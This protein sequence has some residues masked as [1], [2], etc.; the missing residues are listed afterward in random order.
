[1]LQ[2]YLTNAHS[3]SYSWTSF[4]SFTYTTAMAEM[5]NMDFHFQ[6]SI[7]NITLLSRNALSIMGFVYQNFHFV[8]QLSLPF[9]LRIKLR[10][11]E[12]ILKF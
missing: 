4:T 9:H 8:F 6:T 5:F 10:C 7:A 3:D 12:I 2:N 1:M 11:K